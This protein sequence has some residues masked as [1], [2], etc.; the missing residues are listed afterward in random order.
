MLSP[1]TPTIDKPRINALRNYELSRKKSK[2]FDDITELATLVT[3]FPISLISFVEEDEVWF[4]STKGMDICSSDRDL[5]FCSYAVGSKNDIYVVENTKADERFFDHPYA[6]LGEQSVIFYAG[7]C[8]IDKEG[9]RIGTLCVID[10]KPNILSE[11]NK[12]ILQLLASQVMKLVESNKL[13]KEFKKNQKNLKIQN[14]NLKNFAGHVSHDMKMPLAN[15]IVTS[16]ILKMRYSKNLDEKGNEYLNYLKQSSLTL[17]SYISGLLE[18]YE[19]ESLSSHNNETFSLNHLL[20]EII[21]L[22]NINVDCTINFPEKDLKMTTNRTILEQILL[23]LIGNSI[24]YSDKKKTKITLS[25]KHKNDKT[26]IKIEDNGAGIPKNNL[27]DIFN[28]F[29]T[30]GQ[31]DRYGNKGHGIGLSTVKKLVTELGGKI[32]VKSKL[33]VGTTFIFSIKD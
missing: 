28:L 31:L 32:K 27:K 1:T 12:K 23:N 4:K 18:H 33:D 19:S 22:L 10:H 17:S 20:E 5:S 7:I 6:N 3:G 25:Y 2:K 16:D 29:T 11:K 13:N 24:K 30:V 9:F 14:K 15:M 21:D 8:L 26:F